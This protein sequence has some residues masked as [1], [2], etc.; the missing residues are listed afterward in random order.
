MLFKDRILVLG[1][2]INKSY[3][4]SNGILVYDDRASSWTEVSNL[5]IG[6]S[7]CIAAILS[8]YEIFVCGGCTAAF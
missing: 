4:P 1:G 7:Q 3:N 2:A 5:N 8:K 6:R